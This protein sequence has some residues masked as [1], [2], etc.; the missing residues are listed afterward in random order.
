M[1]LRSCRDSSTR[2]FAW[3]WKFEASGRYSH[4]PAWV[5]ATCAGSGLTMI[6]FRTL[7]SLRTEKGVPIK[8]SLFV[9]EKD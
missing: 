7:E 6:H 3:R 5:E 2:G 1:S 8:G 4:N 9:F